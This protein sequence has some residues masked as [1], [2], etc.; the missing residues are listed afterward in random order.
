M[1]ANRQRRFEVN[2][3]VVVRRIAEDVLLVPISGP[4]AGACVYPVNRT[5]LAIWEC[6]SVGGTLAEAA[7]RLVHEFGAAPEEAQA[8]CA[9][10]AQSF[11]AESLLRERPD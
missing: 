7:E 1:T 11:M 8:D 4:A 6:L 3:R 10:C 9:A 5:A 2:G